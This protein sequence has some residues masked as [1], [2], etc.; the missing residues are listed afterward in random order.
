MRMLCGQ[1]GFYHI[2]AVFEP[3]RLDDAHPAIGQGP[4]GHTVALAL[5]PLAVAV[6]L[7]PRFAEGRL[8]GKLKEDIAEGFD[9][10]IAPMRLSLFA[11]LVGHWRGPGQRLHAGGTRIPFPVVAPSCPQPGR[12]AFTGPW[13]T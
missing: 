5:L 7:R 13:E 10:G 9:A 4:H 1:E 8:P 12:K 3:H 2:G 11:T 6:R